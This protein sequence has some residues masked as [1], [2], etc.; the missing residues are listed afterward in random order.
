MNK[1]ALAAATAVAFW[2]AAPVAAQQ[3]SDT[4]LPGW[5][6]GNWLM[7]NGASWSDEFWTQP[8]GGMM[9]GGARS[10]FGP[11]LEMWE[12]TRIMRK[13]DG[14]ISLYAQPRGKEASEFPMVTSGVQS[15]EFA[16]AAHDYPQRI[17]YWRQ[18]QLLMA[19]IAKIDG[20]DAVRWNYRPVAA[21]E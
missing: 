8:R 20:S 3:L 16:N 10:G 11:G 19:E 5:M 18:G 15:V 13:A 9:I 21:G 12:T 7:E 4:D 14:S 1:F 17:R 2:L 6:A